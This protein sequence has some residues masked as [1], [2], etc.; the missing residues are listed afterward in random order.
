MTSPRYQGGRS[1]VGILFVIILAGVFVLLALRLVPLY[2]DYR[3]ITSIAA[4]VQEDTDYRNAPEEDVRDGLRAQMRI[5]NLR[6]YDDEEIYAISRDDDDAL[7]IE[8]DYEERVPFLFNIDLIAS[9]E[10]RVG[11]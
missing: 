3:T 4:S 11:P 10:R 9:F 6:G 2:I 8:I 5:N 1:L 7:V